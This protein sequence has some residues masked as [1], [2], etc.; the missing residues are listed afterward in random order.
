MNAAAACRPAWPARRRSA[1]TLFEIIIVLLLACLV[2]GMLGTFVWRNARTSR[3]TDRKLQ[4]ISAVHYLAGR[5]RR[6]L[7]GSASF[8]IDEGGKR[9]TMTDAAG[10]KRVYQYD[11]QERTLLVPDVVDPTASVRY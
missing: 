2:F 3:A 1:F 4:A 6:D 10:R 7:K 8:A 11:P 5:L 9:L